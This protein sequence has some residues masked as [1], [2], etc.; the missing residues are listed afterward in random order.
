[1]ATY[2]VSAQTGNNTYSGTAEDEA[3]LTIQ[4]GLDLLSTGGDILY[5]APGTYRGP[6]WGS[7][8]SGSEGNPIKIIGDM[9]CEQ[10]TGENPGYIRVT[11]AT[12][13]DEMTTLTGSPGEPTHLFDLWG[14]DEWEI[15]NMH[16]DGNSNNDLSVSDLSR[17]TYASTTRRIAFYNCAWT[18]FGRTAVQG[19]EVYDSFISSSYIGVVDCRVKNSVIMAG[20][21]AS[22]GNALPGFSSLTG[23]ILTSGYSCGYKTTMYNCINLGAIYAT[24]QCDVNNS[25][26]HSSYYGP[27][28]ND[29]DVNARLNNVLVQNS[30]FLSRACENSTTGYWDSNYEDTYESTTTNWTQ[31]GMLRWDPY[32]IREHLFKAFLP[33]DNI[34]LVGIGD[35]GLSAALT[36]DRFGEPTA[37]VNG[38]KM[39]GPYVVDRVSE[40]FDSN[41][42]NSTG[43]GFVIDGVGSKSFDLLVSSGY[44]VSISAYTKVFGTPHEDATL[45]IWGEGITTSSSG[46]MSAD[47]T[48]LQ[49]SVSGSE[50]KRDQKIH[51]TIA[52][53]DSSITAAFSDIR[54]F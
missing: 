31:T 37:G 13:A 27:Y 10:F 1:M 3:K 48:A 2:Y 17:G 40:S 44:D 18:N 45:S 54:V 30:R 46:S 19:S 21:Y 25:I 34:G 41:H 11:A 47:W 32:R 28:N 15:Y 23:C 52:N 24:V 9:H 50:I 20:Y 42:Y 6:I 33:L 14:E 16:F 8:Q 5:I 43:P 35:A 39:I 29:V 51:F 26:F 7:G 12:G 4:A 38:D 22:Y 49:V 53:T 36:A